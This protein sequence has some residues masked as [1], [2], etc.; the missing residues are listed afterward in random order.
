MSNYKEAS[1]LKLRFSTNKGMLSV[2]N[3]WD[4][5]IPELDDL[6]ISLEEDYKESGKKSFITKRSVKDKTK[7]LQFDIVLD[8]LNTKVEEEEAARDAKLTKE[9]NDKIDAL[10]AK[11]QESALEDK[12]IAE[13]E[14]LRK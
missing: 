9:H 1:K 8:I 6:A 3:L 7:K 13:L 5:S 11:K 2:D 10:I 4:L 14:A 12:S